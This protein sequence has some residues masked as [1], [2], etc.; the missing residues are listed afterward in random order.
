MH[1]RSARPYKLLSTVRT[2]SSFWLYSVLFNKH[3]NVTVIKR[4]Q[5]SG[6]LI[7]ASERV[8][9]LLFEPHALRAKGFVFFAGALDAVGYAGE[10]GLD[11]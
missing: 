4:K 3:V 9:Q 5:K 2:F 6:H 10:T 8:Q 11:A 7:Q 1:T